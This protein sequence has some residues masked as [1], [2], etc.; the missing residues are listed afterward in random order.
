M[1]QLGESS[2]SSAGADPSN[3]SAPWTARGGQVLQQN[4]AQSGVT[5]DGSQYLH[6]ADT[7]M[8]AASTGGN[9]NWSLF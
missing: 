5:R 4:M 7:G 2:W 9:R 8:D 1:P 3:R 6:D